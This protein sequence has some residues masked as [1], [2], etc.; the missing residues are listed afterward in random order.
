MSDRTRSTNDPADSPPPQ[1]VWAFA[2]DWY[3][4]PTE[5]SDPDAPPTD[6]DIA[7][8]RM[9]AKARAF[10][11]KTGL[12]HERGDTSSDISERSMG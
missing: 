11:R 4:P 10:A 3:L 1:K 12:W 9:V 6:A 8:D 7:F 5:E 2:V